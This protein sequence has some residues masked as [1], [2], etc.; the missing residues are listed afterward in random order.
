V[1]GQRKAGQVVDAFSAPASLLQKAAAAALKRGMTKTG[2]YRYCLAKECGYSEAEAQ[3]L[4]THRAVTNAKEKLAERASGIYPPDRPDN[5]VMNTEGKE[6][7]PS[8]TVGDARRSLAKTGADGVVRGTPK[9]G[10][11]SKADESNE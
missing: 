8:S 4:A 2:F 5:Y 3:A 10:Q 9:R 6:G 1:P 11:K 7:P